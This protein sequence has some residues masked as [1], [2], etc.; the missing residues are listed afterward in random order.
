MNYIFLM[1]GISLSLFLHVLCWRTIFIGYTMTLICLCHIMGR[2]RD[3]IFLSMMWHS[4]EMCIPMR[5]WVS[6][7]LRSVVNWS[8]LHSIFWLNSMGMPVVRMTAVIGSRQE[9]WH[10]LSKGAL[11]NML[12]LNIVDYIS[13]PYAMHALNLLNYFIGMYMVYTLVQW[14]VL[15]RLG[16]RVLLEHHGLFF[17]GLSWHWLVVHDVNWICLWQISTRNVLL[18]KLKFIKSESCANIR[19]NSV[20]DHQDMRFHKAACTQKSYAKGLLHQS[21]TLTSKAVAQSCDL[22]ALGRFQIFP[23]W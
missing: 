23:Y 4:I 8:S 7:A 2:W 13:C 17:L 11:S 9:T 1:W 3:D 16:R 18:P 21:N 12:R 10:Q 5:P 19:G 20:W 15:S 22:D 6:H 14:L